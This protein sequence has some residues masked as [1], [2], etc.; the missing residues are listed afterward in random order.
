MTPEEKQQWA[1]TMI[2]RHNQTVRDLRRQQEK[3]QARID[4]LN[5]A[6]GVLRRIVE[7]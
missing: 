4:N 6:I 2:R 1:S 5:I 7:G 3:A